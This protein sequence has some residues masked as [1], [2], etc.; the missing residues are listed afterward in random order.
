MRLPATSLYVQGN[1]CSRTLESWS[2]AAGR[3]RSEAHPHLC[4]QVATA[5]FSKTRQVFT[6]PN[7][8]LIPLISWLAN[9]SKR[10][11]PQQFPY[12]ICPPPQLPVPTHNIEGI[13]RKPQNAKSHGAVKIE[14]LHLNKGV[15]KSH[16]SS[17][18]QGQESLLQHS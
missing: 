14:K 8:S 17:P 10:S 16:L 18:Q 11:R 2:W 12:F 6:A 7:T 15:L 3:L 9:Q 1:R 4:P 13:S 5:S